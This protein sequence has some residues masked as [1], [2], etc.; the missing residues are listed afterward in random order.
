MAANSEAHLVRAFVWMSVK[1][2]PWDSREDA[3]RY[4]DQALGARAAAAFHEA[5]PLCEVR[6]H[7]IADER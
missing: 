5:S 6:M 3:M 7:R 4:A 1:R 2:Q